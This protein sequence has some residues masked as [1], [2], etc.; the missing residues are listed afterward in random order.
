MTST[1]VLIYLLRRDLRLADNPIFHDLSRSTSQNGQLTPTHVLPLYVFPAQQVEVSGFLSSP[2]KTSP[3]PEARSQVGGFWRCGPHRARYLAESVWDLKSHL[4][5]V[6]SG[7][8]IRVGMVGDVISNLL[9][10]FKEKSLDTKVVGVWMTGEEGVEE[11]REEREV[12]AIAQNAGVQ[13]KLWADE[14][15]FIDDRDVPYKRP[16]DIPDVFTSYRKSV[17]PLRQAP[18]PVLPTPKKIPPFPPLSLIP[19]QTAPFTAPNDLASTIEALEAPLN[20][21]KDLTK[22][23]TMPSKIKS[24]HP[25]GGGETAAQARLKHL[26]ASGAMTDYKDTRNGL[27]GTDFSTKLS[28]P[29]ALGCL[30]ARQIHAALLAF[31]EGTSGPTGPGYGKGE[32][33]GS[34]AVRFELLWRDY[35]RLCTRKFGPKLFDVHGFRQAALASWKSPSQARR[36][37][38]GDEVRRQLTRFLEGRT[39]MGLIDASMRELYLTGYT[40]NRA[41]QN[42]ASFLAK[43]LGI[44]WRLGAEWYES[45]LLDY[46]VSSNWG[47][48][49]YVAG[50]GNDPR[51]SDRV[52]NPVKQGVDYDA[53]GEYV[54]AW[55]PELRP[56]DGLME[57]LQPWKLGGEARE[58]HGLAGD[59]MVENPLVKIQWSSGRGRGGGGGG[60]GG[61][62]GGGRG[63]GRGGGRG[64]ASDGYRGNGRRGGGGGAS[65]G[66]RRS[67]L[68]DREYGGAEY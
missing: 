27:L 36:G 61:G 58:K 9:R 29:L 66:Q 2:D 64:G 67:G 39:G 56:V 25:F 19:E 51:G 21:S 4:E 48:W 55:V 34:A 47:N 45:L 31:E 53:K 44:D 1:R 37:G 52:F 14:K 43:H 57:V 62:S 5:D 12:K 68:V 16:L 32:T 7:L 24:A 18:R 38:G 10:D 33:K 20:V 6:G 3:Y 63:R 49:Q 30:T 40:S 26:I 42:V 65:R 17:E 35:M 13:F 59:E 28:A 15:Y 41:R 60:G 22:P 11:K 8:A 46:D 50:V 54:R 23:P